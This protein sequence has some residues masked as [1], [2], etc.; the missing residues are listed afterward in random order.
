MRRAWQ[1]KHFLLIVLVAFNTVFLLS[2]TTAVYMGLSYTLTDQTRL[3]RMDLVNVNFGQIDS[4][5]RQVEETAL[6]VSTSRNLQDAL[7]H[8]G[9]DADMYAAVRALREIDYWLNGLAAINPDIDRIKVYAVKP[10]PSVSSLVLSVSDIPWREE[11]SRL[12]EFDSIWMPVRRERRIPES[13]NVLTHVMKI[14]DRRNALI[15]YVE[16]N[17]KEEAIQRLLYRNS[18]SSVPGEMFL[19]LDPGGRLMSGLP[20]SGDAEAWAGRLEPDNPMNFSLAEIDQVNYMYIYTPKAAGSWRLVNIIRVDE[21]YRS[22]DALRNLVLMIGL[23]AI[24]LTV[25]LAFFLAK[26][27]TRPVAK[28]IE[29]FGQVKRGIFTAR[30]DEHAIVEF[31][32][33]LQG[34][35]LMIRRLEALLEQLEEEHRLKLDAEFNMLQSQINPHFLYNT[36]DMINWMAAKRGAD[37]VSMM[38]TRLARLFRI[39]LSSGG[40]L[41]PLR[42]ELEHADVYTQ[43]QQ[44]RFRDKFVYEV[45]VASKHRAYYVPRVIIQPFIENAIVHGFREHDGQPAKVVVRTEDAGAD[46]FCLIVE[47]NGAGL[48]DKPSDAAAAASGGALPAMRANGSSGYG[49]RNVNKR[50]KLLLGQRYGAT[51]HNREEG[52]A[53]VHI[54]LPVVQSE[55]GQ[56]TRASGREGTQ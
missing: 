15:G 28:L 45:N 34:Y 53:A 47:D 1:L 40:P 42:E 6:S 24:A 39:S 2:V 26:R 21:L 30:M 55:D 54:L 36:L 38:A 14:F 5:L 11:L 32:E 23:A 49:I 27:I 8:S 9:T 13:R 12:E 31:H 56:V 3:T 17:L 43:I 37:D 46:A 44:E 51:L 25:P 20:R 22:V 48:R 52:G 33:L 4:S 35:N 16:V 50:I 19:L 10:V 41:I 29:A 18:R 7:L